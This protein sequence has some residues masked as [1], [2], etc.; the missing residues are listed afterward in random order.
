MLQKQYYLLNFL[1]DMIM[2]IL[3]HPMHIQ[4]KEQNWIYDGK[5][6]AQTSDIR[7]LRRRNQAL[8]LLI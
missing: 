8:L 2:I 4:T 7:V 1:C 3:K 6:V 5:F